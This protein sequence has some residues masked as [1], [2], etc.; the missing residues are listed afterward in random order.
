MLFRSRR[1]F[2]KNQFVIQYFPKSEQV[3]EE[4]ISTAE[5]LFS[6]LEYVT[7]S[8]GLLRGTDMHYE[9]VDD[10]LNFFVNY[11]CF[12]REQQEDTPLESVEIANYVKE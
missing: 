8:E 3:N 5:R 6:C 10:V 9:I 2:R 1:Y 7:V 4:C 12:V 11:D